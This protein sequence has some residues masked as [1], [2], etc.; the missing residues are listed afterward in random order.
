MTVSAP[1]SPVS[2]KYT[3]TPTLFSMM[4]RGEHCTRFVTSAGGRN[5]STPRPE[6]EQHWLACRGQQ[7]SPSFMSQSCCSRLEER[8]TRQPRGIAGGN[9]PRCPFCLYLPRCSLIATPA[10]WRWCDA[11]QPLP[12]ADLSEKTRIS[13][14]EGESATTADCSH[15][16][17]IG[18]LYNSLRYAATPP[19]GKPQGS[20]QAVSPRRFLPALNQR[21]RR[22]K[23]E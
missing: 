6:S 2:W 5:R 12:D 11:V 16:G 13:S 21:S 15:A 22:A 23:I 18:D 8:A 4:V 1:C 3:P 9:V 7:L 10:V 14:Q 20:K 17:R 19:P